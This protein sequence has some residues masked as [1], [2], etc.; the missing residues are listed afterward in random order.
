MQYYGNDE[1]EEHKKHYEHEGDEV[2]IGDGRAAIRRHEA[3]VTVTAVRWVERVEHEGAP[4]VARE[5]LEQHVGGA[6]EIFS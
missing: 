5:A 1:V 4:A 2:S 6:G 3:R